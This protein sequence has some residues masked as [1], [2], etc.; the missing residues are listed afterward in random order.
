[1]ED[2]V[3]KH[4]L[5]NDR[6]YGHQPM[7]LLRRCR[8]RLL[9]IWKLFNVGLKIWHRNPN[10]YCS[11]E[12]SIPQNYQRDRKNALE[13]KNFL[14]CYILSI[15]LYGSETL[16]ICRQEKI[17]VAKNFIL[18][19]DSENPISEANKEKRNLKWH[20][21]EHFFSEWGIFSWNC[22]GT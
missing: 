21:K 6:K 11:N 18:Q 19:N 17:E 4:Q 2:A 5:Q 3:T 10:I 7:I 13:T 16:I 15:H 12:W 8:Y 20:Q 9:N 14:D 1:M 22:F